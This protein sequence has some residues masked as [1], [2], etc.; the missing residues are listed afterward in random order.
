MFPLGFLFLAVPM[1]AGLIP[2]LMEFT[3]D[4][5]E[6]LLRASGIPVLREGLYL[7]LPTGTWSVI[8]ECSGVRY[9]I[10]SF[11][12][13]LFYA[14]L[15]YYSLWRRVAFMAAAIIVPILAN[16]VRAYG[17]VMVGHLSDMRF[18]VG[19]D[20]LV[21]GWVFFGLVML[22]M[23]WVGGFWQQHAPPP[24]PAPGPAPESAK[25]RR[26]KPALSLTLGTC[27]TVLCAG[28]WPALAFSMN[29]NTDPVAAAALAIPTEMGA[30]QT[31]PIEDWPWRPGQEGADRE[32]NRI[33][34]TTSLASPAPVSVG[35]HLRQYLQQNAGFEL[36]TNTDPWRPDRKAWRV[37]AQGS[38]LIDL[39]LPLRVDE[40]RVIS[41]RDNLLVWSWYRIDGRNTAN[42]YIAKLLEAKQQMVAGRRQGAR[43]FIATPAGEDSS[44]A[45]AVL[46]EFVTVYGTAIAAALDTGVA[47][48]M[49]ATAGVV[50]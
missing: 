43:V 13:G 35:L 27:L 45:R 5:T 14:Y 23:F 38:T 44:Q 12:L 30:W 32:L 28:A 47:D 29:R 3:A 4:T 36:V 41:A 22:L 24:D 25:S 49:T 26:R 50:Q 31:M 11:T 21:Y 33:Y 20:H 18:G 40:V 19:A 17:V 1:G 9:L 15:T 42:P 48:S 39:G 16:S 8:E 2:P 10:A 37:M 7:S 34:A 46:Q 6:F